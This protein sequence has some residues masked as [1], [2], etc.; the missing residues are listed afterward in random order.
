MASVYVGTYQKYNNGSIGGAWVDLTNFSNEDEFLEHCKELHKDEKDPEFMLQDF[1]EFP[2]AYYS[3][4]GLDSELWEW[5]ALDDDDKEILEA[6]VDCMGVHA[7]IDE[8]RDA[9]VGQYDSDIDFT[10]E[11][12]ES[13]GDIPK[14]LPSY[15]HIDWEGTARDIM[16]DY[17]E[18]NG[19]YF[20]A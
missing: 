11:L 7:T 20:R 15:I 4:S 8:A 17:S 16:M 6:Y 14:D 10:M 5:L 12:L 2:K 3:E 18:H 9:F 13:C 1:E 19:F